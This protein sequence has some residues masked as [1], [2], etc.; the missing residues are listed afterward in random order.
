MKRL[1]LIVA[2]LLTPGVLLAQGGRA[3]GPGTSADFSAHIVDPQTMQLQCVFIYRGRPGWDHM[4]DAEYR[5]GKQLLDSA[6]RAA[7]AQRRGVAGTITPRGDALVT[8]DHDSSVVFVKGVRYTLP[9]RDSTLVLVLD[10]AD[11]VG[12]P[13]TVSQFT[14]RWPADRY[15]P[16]ERFKQMEAMVDSWR[17]RILREPRV[18]QLLRDTVSR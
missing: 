16:E 2:V 15:G 11:G 18:R 17:D 13:P 8:I 7:I 6:V 4:T 5:V 9:K 12:G 1:S 14:L 3:L 10:R